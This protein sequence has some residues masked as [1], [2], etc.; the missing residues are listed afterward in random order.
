M[1]TDRTTSQHSLAAV[2]EA[3]AEQ[4]PDRAAIV[5]RDRRFTH[6][7]LTTRTR[8]LAHVLHDR[9]L[10][11]RP[12]GRAG[13]GPYESH[14]DHLAVYAYNGNEYLEAMIGA[15]KARVVPVNVNYRYVAEELRYVLRN[16]AAKA[17]LYHSAFAPTLAEVLADLPELRVLLQLE[18]GSGNE[19]LPG[20]EWYEEALAEA[21]TSIPQWAPDWSPDDLYI[22]YTGGTT[23]APKGVLWRQADVHRT[24]L[25]GRNPITRQPWRTL[26]ELAEFAATNPT[27]H[28]VLAASPYMHG[29]GHWTAL[30]GLNQG[31]TVVIQDNVERL[32]PTDVCSV[33]GRER[34]TYLQMIGDAFARPIIEE[35]E[36]GDYDLSSLRTILSGGMALTPAV[37]TRL[38][39]RMPAVTLVESVGSSEGG[40]QAVRT[41]TA[42]GPGSTGAFY[43]VA[44][45]V[46]VSADFDSVLGPGADDVGWLAKREDIPLGYLGDPAKT[47]QA[48]P[49]VAGERMVVPG[50]RAQWLADGTIKLLG[51]DSMTI[52]SGGEKIFAEEVEAAIIAHPDVSDVVV[53]SRPSQRW[54]QE[55]VAIVH[56]RDGAT[57]AE[58]DLAAEAAR[59]VARYKLP[60]AWVFV[61]AIQRTG[62]GKADYR[63]AAKVAA[64]AG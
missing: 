13:L 40:G 38:L 10:G 47:A 53:A 24:A 16:S 27:P 63:W 1:T 14:Q 20:A 62:A 50:D 32:D 25:G 39:A 48:F 51:R 15:F 11:A 7:Q 37:E 6:A 12:Q 56:L 44:G 30:L 49:V 59:H 18:D 52:N 21:P 64:S 41:I 45:S 46:V 61:D 58:D 29:A 28:V 36:R 26:D 3:V 54:G 60:K 9:G 19:L 22:V 33:V 23:G 17:I 57:A 42:T 2:S 43:P 8:Q 35:M 31:G 5:F 55:V 4:V 34:V